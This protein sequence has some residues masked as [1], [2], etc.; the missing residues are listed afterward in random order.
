[1]A[2]LRPPP[3]LTISEWAQAK[4]KL[5]PEASAEAGDWHNERFPPLVGIMEAIS[6]PA[7]SDISVEKSAQVGVSE[8]ILNA[9]GYHIDLDPCPMLY[10]HPTVE[11]A[12]A[13]S[14][15]RIDPMVRDGRDGCLSNKVGATKQTESTVLQKRFVGGH[16]SLGGANSA[17]SLAGRPVRIAFFDDVDRF[18][19]SAGTGQNKEGDPI[20]LGTKRTN[21]FYN[22]Q[23]IKVSTPTLGSNSRIHRHFL[24]GDRRLLMLACPQCG[25]R[26]ALEWKQLKWE[27]GKAETAYY[28]CNS[29]NGCVINESDKNG[30]LQ[31]ILTRADKGWTP[32]ADG[33]GKISFRLNELCSVWRTWAEVVQ[34]FLDS[35]DDPF[36]LQVFVNTV[37]GEVWNDAEEAAPVSTNELVER[38]EDYKEPPDGCLILLGT[39]DTQDDRLEMEIRGF[40]VGLETWGISYNVIYGSPALPQVW[41]QA[42]DWFDKTVLKTPCGRELRIRG[43]GVDSGGHH[44]KMVYSFVAQFR[45]K[46]F[47][48]FALR[49]IEGVGQPEVSRAS[50]KGVQR[51]PVFLVGTNTIKENLFMRLKKL[52]PG[53]AYL[54]WNMGYDGEYFEQLLNSERVVTRH[55]S[56]VEYKVFEKRTAGARNEALDL[57]VYAYAVLALLQ[58]NLRLL[59]QRAERWMKDR[60]KKPT[61]TKKTTALP[62]I[63]EDA[64]DE[65]IESEPGPAP[66]DEAEAQDETLDL[67]GGPA[68]VVT[69]R[70]KKKPRRKNW[71]TGYM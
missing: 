17:P 57:L 51:V 67:S 33:H 55:R 18:P 50:I 25:H 22:K 69:Q 6:D 28:L 47:P 29:G 49:G 9:I 12:E 5:S 11:M 65:E 40:G 44:T 38:R 30:M 62:Q 7:N 20:K 61:P 13:F 45:K 54:H 8:C 1:M 56:G 66:V 48:V 64:P 21:N 42:Y 19:L 58:L 59:Q 15:D 52:E 10:V 46:R 27:D 43:L 41:Q 53:P 31:E 4:R 24:A 36:T 39:I 16:L 63:P 70:A 14:K 32:T 2:A 3:K 26:Q 68:P 35:K 71:T 23:S 60:G 34:D 37:L